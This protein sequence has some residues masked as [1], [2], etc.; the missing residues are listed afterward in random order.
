VRL[1]QHLLYGH[2]RPGRGSQPGEVLPLCS[3][4]LA[5]FFGKLPQH[6]SRNYK[7]EPDL[8]RFRARVLPGLRWSSYSEG[9]CRIAEDL[10]LPPKLEAA[11][12]RE[13]ELGP[14][15]RETLAAGGRLVLFETG[16]AV[17]DLPTH[18]RRLRKRQ[19]AAA[20]SA[21]HAA[22]GGSG[23]ENP[24]GNGGTGAGLP[25]LQVRVLTYMNS[26]PANSFALLRK[27]MKEAYAEAWRIQDPEK[28]RATL[29]RL[30]RIHEQ[31]Q[32]FY[33]PTKQ[34]GTARIYE[35]GETLANLKRGVRRV[36][37]RG[38]SEFDLKAAQLAIVS[39]HWKVPE[40]RGLIEAS[41]GGDGSNESLGESQAA[42]LKPAPSIWHVFA[43][44]I[45]LGE[46]TRT[47]DW[48]QLKSAL[49]DATYALTYG[50]SEKNIKEGRSTESRGS[51]RHAR[52]QL[53]TDSGLTEA[54][55]PAFAQAMAKSHA[56]VHDGVKVAMH[57][58]EQAASGQRSQQANDHLSGGH[59][60]D[61]GHPEDDAPNDDSRSDGSVRG[62][63]GGLRGSAVG[64][65]E[66]LAPFASRLGAS[67]SP[68][69]LADKFL[70]L[71]PVRALK[72]QRDAQIAAMLDAGSAQ[73][74]FGAAF[75][76]RTRDEARSALARQ[77]QAI[78]LKLLEPALAL[79]EAE[80][81]KKDAAFQIVLWQHDGFSVKFRRKADRDRLSRRIIEAVDAEARRL[82]IPTRL[83]VEHL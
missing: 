5:G 16:E 36:L 48:P 8:E 19:K 44:D 57:P 54:P 46:V 7:A 70:G 2:R 67:D 41:M 53:G 10:G 76:V 58:S 64:L 39:E 26:R 38:W 73:D 33:G 55:V 47:G 79:A 30:A 4:S 18:G 68:E 28:R 77:A 45:G 78:E 37:T 65:A 60:D 52:R 29:R 69:D 31:P 74:C 9:Q 75:P 40:L 80:D 3:R 15:E 49:K 27:N 11:W 50:S 42:T 32:P 12:K 1:L 14:D 21:A 66:R 59:R 22:A 62:L 83:E 82:G 61:G 43:E 24:N 71:A 81:Q 35:R 51:D 34:G 20:M 17:K 13:V 56:G 23:D 6:D 72:R 63:E 25:Q